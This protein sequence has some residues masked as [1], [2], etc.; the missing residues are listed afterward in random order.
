ML[1][2]GMRHEVDR[3]LGKLRGKGAG[4]RGRGRYDIKGRVSS[5]VSSFVF[6]VEYISYSS[7]ATIQTSFITMA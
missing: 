5:C 7:S 2:Q 1:K 4:T 3:F 6:G